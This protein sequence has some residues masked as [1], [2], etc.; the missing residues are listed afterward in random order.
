MIGQRLKNISLIQTMMFHDKQVEYVQTGR[1][2]VEYIRFTYHN[3]DLVCD[4]Y[5]IL[6][7]LFKNHDVKSIFIGDD[8]FE[9]NHE[10][11]AHAVYRLRPNNSDDEP[12]DEGLIEITFKSIRLSGYSDNI[13]IGWMSYSVVK[14]LL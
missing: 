3:P 12:E 8:T 5:V 1:I 9:S 4:D 2:L 11:M 13:F 10:L 14:Y 6:S 7:K